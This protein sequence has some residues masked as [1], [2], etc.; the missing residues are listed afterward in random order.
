MQFFAC[1]VPYRL[2]L[3][4]CELSVGE[5]EALAVPNGYLKYVKFNISITNASYNC[6]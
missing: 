1:L 2:M 5:V 3:V 4:L 6:M